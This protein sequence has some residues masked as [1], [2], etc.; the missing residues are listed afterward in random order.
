MPAST[1]VGT[2]LVLSSPELAEQTAIP[3][4][5][6]N[7]D[8]KRVWHDRAAPLANWQERHHNEHFIALMDTH[9]PHWRQHQ[10]TLNRSPLAHEA[11][12]Y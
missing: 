7:I 3:T 5:P 11:W 2:A 8:T 12:A 1:E 9:M 10:A 6:S 4:I